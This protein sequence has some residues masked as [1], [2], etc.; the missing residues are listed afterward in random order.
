VI[1]ETEEDKTDQKDNA[2][3]NGHHNL[4]HQDPSLRWQSED[5]PRFSDL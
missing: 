2:T 5:R 4:F 1:T 3:I